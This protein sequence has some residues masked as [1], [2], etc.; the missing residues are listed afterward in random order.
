MHR[1]IVKDHDHA[2]ELNCVLNEQSMERFGAGPGL[3]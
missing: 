3:H 1:W 2:K